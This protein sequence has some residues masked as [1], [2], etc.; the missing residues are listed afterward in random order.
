M[1]YIGPIMREAKKLYEEEENE[2]KWL[3]VKAEIDDLAEVEA[4]ALAAAQR[5]EKNQL[6]ASSINSHNSESDRCKRKAEHQL[7]PEAAKRMQRGGAPNA[8]GKEKAV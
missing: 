5:E 1:D 2:R 8:A 3:E 6:T 7:Q 4:D